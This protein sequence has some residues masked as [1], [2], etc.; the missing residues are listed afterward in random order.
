ML[1]ES[2]YPALSVS[3][4][5]LFKQSPCLPLWL[6]TR[7]KKEAV[8]RFALYKVRS[9]QETSFWLLIS[10]S[11]EWE[12][13]LGDLRRPFQ[14]WL[15][16]I[17]DSCRPSAQPV[18]ASLPTVRWKSGRAEAQQQSGDCGCHAPDPGEWPAM[19]RCGPGAQ[20][21]SLLALLESAQAARM[22][23]C[24]LQDASPV[25]GSS[26]ELAGWCCLKA[27]VKMDTWWPEGYHPLCLVNYHFSDWDASYPWGGVVC[28]GVRGRLVKLFSF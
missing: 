14:P 18:F 12:D 11:V 13:E 4:A 1:G 6:K 17:R 16:V 28:Q 9:S 25:Q 27:K 19:G 23:G 10:S 5:C 7:R 15:A 2:S 24:T 26:S 8:S 21:S 3:E 20:A 22:D